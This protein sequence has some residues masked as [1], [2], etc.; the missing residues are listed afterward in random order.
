MFEAK[1]VVQV[2]ESLRAAGCEVWIGGGW[3]I[4]ALVGRV[5][6]DHN[7]LD[8]LHRVEQE[9]EVIAVLEAAG[10]TERA[11][12]VPGRPARFVMAGPGEIDLHPLEFGADGSAIQRLDDRGGHFAYPADAFARGVIEG[13]MVQCLSVAQQVAFH[14]GY[15][16][17]ER[18]VHDM[19]RLREAFGVATHF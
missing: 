14:Q 5:T 19:A 15:E 10:Y 9:P 1:T 13:V 3:G 17:R 4:D 2:V 16:P 18:D 8:L 11:G 12:V 6:R 7:D